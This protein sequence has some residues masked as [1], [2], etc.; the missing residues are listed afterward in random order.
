MNKKLVASILSIAMVVVSITY[1]PFIYDVKSGVT[2]HTPSESGW[3]LKWSDEFKGNSLNSDN[4]NI[5][6]RIPSEN[7]NNELQ[8]YTQDNVSVENGNLKIKAERRNDGNYYSGRIDSSRKQEFKYGM[9]EARIKVDNGNQ[10]GL[11]PAFWME[12]NSHYNDVPWPRCGELDIM[13]HANKRNYYGGCI[14]W[15][16]QTGPDTYENRKYGSGIDRGE[17]KPYSQNQDEEGNILDLNEGICKYH[18]YKVV[19]DEERIRWFID[20]EETHFL[21]SDISSAYSSHSTFNGD[22]YYFLLNL[23][24]GSDSTPYTHTG[25]DASTFQTATMCV[26]YVRAYEYQNTDESIKTNS[27]ITSNSWTDVGD[28][29][30][31]SSFNN[32]DDDETGII[33]KVG[34]DKDDSSHIKVKNI[35]YSGSLYDTRVIKLYPEFT[36][37]VKKGEKLGISWPVF[38]NETGIAAC[39]SGNNGSVF[40]NL[41]Q[42]LNILE[43]KLEYNQSL[44][45]AVVVVMMGDTEFGQSIEFNE[46]TIYG[47][48]ENIAI[49]EYNSYNTSTGVQI[50]QNGVYTISLDHIKAKV[51]VS[52]NDPNHLRLSYESGNSYHN[53]NFKTTI[54]LGES[55]SSNKTYTFKMKIESTEEGDIYSNIS[56]NSTYH[57]NKG[58]NEIE[59]QF[60]GPEMSSVIFGLAKLPY[61]TILDYYDLTVTDNSTGEVV[62]PV[63]SKTKVVQYTYPKYIEYITDDEEES[64]YPYMEGYLFAGWYGDEA[65]TRNINSNTVYA[66]FIDKNVLKTSYQKGNDGSA[67]RFLS[68]ID[69]L[70]YQNVGFKIK[71]NY[72]G[73]SISEQEKP[74]SKVYTSILAAGEKTYPNDPEHFSIDSNYFFTYTVKG[75]NKTTAS[76]WEITPYYVTHDGLKVYGETR[77]ISFPN[78][79][80]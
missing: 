68:T 45:T 32:T 31:Q 44:D 25:P 4:W 47:N 23:A 66:K 20:G 41:E 2:H 65:C 63:V 8:Y 3:V 64:R 69:C 38:T 58:I 56:P 10:D 48:T 75:L 72:G 9:L 70:D 14:H 19:W 13:E 51:G 36:D 49:T 40:Y 37:R 34:V 1:S 79:T 7:K 15:A 24:I 50:L 18:T 30:I 11:W 16:K 29:K 42:G 54:N 62:Y 27:R 17:Y 21:S 12:G 77:E 6:E 52:Q 78:G 5:V 33:T 55:F 53:D 39:I 71:G 28:Y 35:G 43:G 76:S 59:R 60:T 73:Q 22:K 61:A 26:D 46:P 57:I 67:L 80:K 74:I